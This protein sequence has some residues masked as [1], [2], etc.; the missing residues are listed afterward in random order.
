[1]SRHRRAVQRSQSTQS[2]TRSRSLASVSASSGGAANRAAA[3]MPSLDELEDGNDDDEA[4]SYEN[5]SVIV[6]V[7]Y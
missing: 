3:R 2:K 6:E 5:H 4:P 1:M 7:R